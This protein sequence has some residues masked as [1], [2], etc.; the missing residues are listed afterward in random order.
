MNHIK[1]YFSLLI[2][3]GLSVLF[4]TLAIN[5]IPTVNTSKGGSVDGY[6][7]PEFQ[8]TPTVGKID[9]PPPLVTPSLV[10][11]K[12]TVTP[13]SNSFLN[14]EP[15]LATNIAEKLRHTPS[16]AEIAA[17]A[18]EMYYKM[19]VPDEAPEAPTPYLQAVNSLNDLPN[20]VYSDPFFYKNEQIYSTCLKNKKPGTTM[21]VKSLGK[22]SDYYLLPFW[23]NS[24]VCGVAL[25]FIKNGFASAGG[26]SEINADQF[27][28]IDANEAINQVKAKI[29]KEILGVPLLVFGGYKEFWE[30]FNPAW[31]ISTIDG[32][33]YFVLSIHG[34]SEDGNVTTYASVYEIM[35]LHK[36]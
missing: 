9:Y 19:N 5:S 21:A 35:E 15:I 4:L 29:P 8:A 33:Q 10:M 11:E 12:P 34:L 28:I 20:I 18:T 31:Q 27:P 14:S 26:W 24:K 36:D 7:P 32:D 2:I 1:K 23:N 30:P 25:I 17:A 13:T 22:I 3:I 6:P 16:P